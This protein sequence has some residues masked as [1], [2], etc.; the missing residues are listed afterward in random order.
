MGRD[1]AQFFERAEQKGSELDKRGI[2][3]TVVQYHCP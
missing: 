1:R 3:G 2:D